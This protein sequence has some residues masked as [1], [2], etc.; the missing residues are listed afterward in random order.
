MSLLNSLA[1]AFFQDRQPLDHIDI[2]QPLYFRFHLYHPMK[3]VFRLLSYS[4]YNNSQEIEP[5]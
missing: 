5:R 2:I 4:P 3:P 1:Q